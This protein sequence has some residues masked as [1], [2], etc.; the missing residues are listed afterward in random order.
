MLAPKDITIL[1]ENDA[2]QKNID[3]TPKSDDA[4]MKTIQSRF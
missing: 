4:Y 3:K 1:K 2:K